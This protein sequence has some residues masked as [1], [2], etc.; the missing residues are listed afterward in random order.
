MEIN[1]TSFFMRRLLFSN[2]FFF[3]F[4]CRKKNKN[5]RRLLL[6]TSEIDQ[7]FFDFGTMGQ[8]AQLFFTVI[9]FDE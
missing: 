5:F 4:L 1:F 7:S 8:N 6:D 2:S 3:L 9:T